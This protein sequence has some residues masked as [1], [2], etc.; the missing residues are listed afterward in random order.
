M[1]EGKSDYEDRGANE[2]CVL[3]S[4]FHFV[5]QG[6]KVNYPFHTNI[7]RSSMYRAGVKK[8]DLNINNVSFMSCNIRSE[9][10]MNF[11]SFTQEINKDRSSAGDQSA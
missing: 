3:C 10:N 6:Q 7:C 8:K 4:T 11:A 2:G 9:L 1:E 5:C